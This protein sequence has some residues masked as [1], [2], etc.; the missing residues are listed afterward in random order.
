M[1]LYII[2][3]GETDWNK[4]KKLQGKA[5]IELNE[6]GRA[7]ARMTGE[8]MRSIPIHMAIS[9][10]LKRAM[11]TA[12]LALGGRDIPV[13]PDER[14]GEMSFGD[15]E[16]LHYHEGSADIPDDMMHCFFRDTDRYQVPPNGES[17]QNVIDR[18][19]DLYEELVNN[20]EN[21]EKNILISSH[22]AASRAFLQSVFQDGDIWQGGVPKNCAVTIVEIK[23]GQVIH[24]ELDHLFYE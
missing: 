24:V 17:F 8:K 7:L 13:I 11:E 14:I 5:D 2:R 23:N 6:N 19:H 9:S 1:K 3:H 16:G 18:T 22:G 4:E 12:R 10:P 21:E 20:P 15:W